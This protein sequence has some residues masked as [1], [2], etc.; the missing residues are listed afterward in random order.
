MASPQERLVAWAKAQVG[1]AAYSG[2]RNKY[3]DYMDKL[4]M[5]NGPKS[6]YDWCDV[7]YDCGIAQCFGADKVQ[8][9]LNQPKGGCGAGCA[10]SAQY[11][12]DMG[13]WSN[14]PSLG[15]QIFFGD[16]D[17]TGVV[18]GYNNSYVYTVEG[19]TGYSQGYRGGA[20]LSRTYD[21]WDSW[22]TGYG[23]PRWDLAG[24]G[25]K[26]EKS[27]LEVDGYLGPAS[28]TAWQQALGTY[29]DG[30]I[31][32]QDPINKEYLYRITSIT[33][34]YGGSQLVRAIQ[35]KVGAGVDGYLGPQTVKAIQK[36]V[37]V[38]QDGYLGPQTAMAV[39]RTLN[40][41]KWR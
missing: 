1:T 35:R 18:V 13:R 3:A 40:D 29:A 38:T 16:Y 19:N 28:V 25:G 34:D 36:F 8:A 12:K 2:K 22:I 15:A 6:G 21:R 14:E 27:G 9:M 32:G 23:T 31:S 30:V 17:H 33:W 37:G 41:G 11:Y 39:Q 10:Y 4:G 7:F 20:V 26:E 5:Y 24:G